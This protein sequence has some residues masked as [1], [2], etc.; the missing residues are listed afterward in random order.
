VLD[1]VRSAVDAGHGVPLADRAAAALSLLL[2][3]GVEWQSILVP[4]LE[5]IAGKA[6]EPAA[7]PA[8]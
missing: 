7:A 4:M 3:T 5:G 6:M 2:S 8:E 1:L